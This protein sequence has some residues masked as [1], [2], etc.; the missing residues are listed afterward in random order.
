MWSVLRP[1]VLFVVILGLAACAAALRHPTSQDALAASA[2]WPGTRVGDLARGR[3]IYVRRCSGCHT[4]VLPAAH[5]ADEWP[6]LVGVMAG[7]ARL[8]PEQQTDVT[9][10]LVTLSRNPT[11][12]GAAAR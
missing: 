7:K 6:A 12:R 8:T 1:S 11:G 3:A 5:H 4:L 9:R 10:F 2:E